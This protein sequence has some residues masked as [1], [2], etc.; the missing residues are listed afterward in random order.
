MITNEQVSSPRHS[1][2]V[3]WITQTFLPRCRYVW[4]A[5]SCRA[6]VWDIYSGR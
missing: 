5:F 2:R 6:V 3:N 4:L 1:D